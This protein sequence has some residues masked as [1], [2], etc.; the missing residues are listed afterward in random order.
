MLSAPCRLR[1]ADHMR[2][3]LVDDQVVL[4]DLNRGRYLGLSGRHAGIVAGVIRSE[5]IDA[6][7]DAGPR[8]QDR[9]DRALAAPLLQARILTLAPGPAPSQPRQV[10]SPVASLDVPDTAME[11]TISPPDIFRFL[12]ATAEAALW[13]RFRSLRSIAEAMAARLSGCEPRRADH[14]PRLTRAVAV[15][16]RLRP[17]TFTSRGKCLFDSLALMLFLTRQGLSAQWVV[18]VSHGPFRAHSW[19]QDGG[20]VLNDLHEH[21]RRFTPILVV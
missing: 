20:Q 19:V 1:L 2:A 11:S 17:L 6:A 5:T 3:C 13:L 14:A 21:V 8:A 10:S 7:D 16:D 15:F 4:L 18:G 12:G 9:V